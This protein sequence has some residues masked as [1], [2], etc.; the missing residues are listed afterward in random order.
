MDLQNSGIENN[1][2]FVLKTHIHDTPDVLVYDKKIFLTLKGR[3]HRLVIGTHPFL[4]FIV[5]KNWDC[6]FSWVYHAQVRRVLENYFR[7]RGLLSY[8]N[9]YCWFKGC[10]WPDNVSIAVHSFI[11]KTDWSEPR[12]DCFPF[13]HL[14]EKCRT[15][16]AAT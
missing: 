15:I 6:G 7:A 12:S 8:P 5:T 9:F 11:P 1:A 3:K 10:P 4:V 2:C 13:W 14:S 16:W